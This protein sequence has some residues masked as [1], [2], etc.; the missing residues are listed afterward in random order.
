[1][2]R[3]L[4]REKVPPDGF[5]A[6]QPETRVWIR[7][8]DYWNWLDNLKAHRVANNI[9]ITPF[10]AE[11]AEDILCRSLPPGHC[12]EKQ[13][14]VEQINVSTRLTFEDVQRGTNVFKEWVGA[15]RPTVDQKT[16]EKRAATCASCFYNVTLPGCKPC[17]GALNIVKGIVGIRKTHSD[18]WLNSCAVC[19]CFLGAKIWFPLESIKTTEE[20]LKRYPEFCWI[21]TEMRENAKESVLSRS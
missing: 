15:G 11:E 20:Q 5:R 19:R 2:Q 12:K 8:G 9:P 21:P 14:G 6:L 16:A 17:Y 18:Q 13:P 10:W 1:M 3:L 7:G 4:Q